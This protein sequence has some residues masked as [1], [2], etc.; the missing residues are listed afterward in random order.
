MKRKLFFIV[1]GWSFVQQENYHPF[2][3]ENT[4]EFG[5]FG[6]SGIVRGAAVVFFGFIGFDAV[7]TAA[8]ES[9]N[10]Q[11]DMPI[12]IIGS[13]LVATVLYVAFSYVMTGMVSYKTFIGDASPA[14]TAF[15]VTGYHVSKH[16]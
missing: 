13:L 2:I 10:P 14:A 16:F 1:L 9:K 4:G 11:K 5:H 15:A 3:P 7:S 6:W 12:G 8:Q